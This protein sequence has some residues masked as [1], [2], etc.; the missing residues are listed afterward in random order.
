MIEAKFLTEDK[1]YIGFS[2]SGHALFDEKGADIVCASV[3]SAVQLTANSITELFG[4]K[5]DISVEKEQI[6]L[7]ISCKDT[8][9]GFKLIESLKLHLS[10]LSEDYKGTIKVITMEVN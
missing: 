4:I 2:V 5:A 10:L 1:R 7:M 3:T 6:K 9:I 8:E